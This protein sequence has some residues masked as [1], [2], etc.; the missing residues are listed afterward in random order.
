MTSCEHDTLNSGF[1]R[2][3]FSFALSHSL[4]KWLYR[5]LDTCPDVTALS[6]SL[7][8]FKL[9]CERDPLCMFGPLTLS[10]V[11]YCKQCTFGCG[12]DT[13]C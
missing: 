8:N 7:A 1:N 9:I 12:Y 3:S 10:L 6:N 2:F 5:S 4:L 13:S 11:R